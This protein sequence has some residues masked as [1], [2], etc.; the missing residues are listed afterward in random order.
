MA[1]SPNTASRHTA[2]GEYMPLTDTFAK[3]IKHTGAPAG[4][5]HTDGGGMYLLVNAGGKYWRMNYRFDDKRKTLALGV[6]PAVSLAKAR[7][8]RDKAR[9]L[10]AEGID[11]STAK[12]E[13]KQAKADAAANTF[14]M[15]ARDWLAKTAADRM[16][17]TQDKLTSWLEKDVIPFIGKMPISTIGPR[18]VLAAL[19][20]MEARGA[21]DSVQR[22]KQVCG[23]VFRYAVATGS[24]ERDVTQDLKGA[25]AKPT[26][27][28]FAAITEPKQAGD[29][30]RSIFDYVGHPT[31]IAALKLSPLVF[32]RPG[33]LRTME[34]AEVDLDAAEWRIPGSKMKMK[35]DHLVPLSKQ[36]V[37]LLRGVQPMT[38]HGRYVFPS[39]RTGERP[40]SENTINAALRGMGY[41]AEVHSA[42]GFRAMA[43]TIMDEVLGERVD[44]IEH[45]LAHAVKDVN[46][47]AYNRTAHLPARRV[48]MQTW[49]DYLDKLRIGADVIPLRTAAK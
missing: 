1:V 3:N 39:L 42:H 40:M 17:T 48:M 20:K 11:P 49:A 19:R 26:A 43:R 18:D 16:P 31:T 38:G 35:V 46:G 6:Y 9:E 30:M 25:L 4:D 13:D 27:G 33:E 28:H 44:L 15:V 8:R 37:E 12:K 23:Q 41:S 21:L 45:Q 24:A 10:L 47:R 22:V 14:E 29:L 5:K 36:A 32:V 34:W 7:Q 2:K